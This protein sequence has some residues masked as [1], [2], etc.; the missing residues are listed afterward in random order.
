MANV[1]ALLIYLFSNSALANPIKPPPL[2]IS[3][4]T[5]GSSSGVSWRRVITPLWE[6]N[7]EGSFEFFWQIRIKLPGDLS[8]KGIQ[9]ERGLITVRESETAGSEVLF[10]MNAIQDTLTIKGSDGR[11]RTFLVQLKL[12]KFRLIYQGCD[13][14]GLEIVSPE[15][16]LKKNKVPSYM[17]YRCDPTNVGFTLSIS[18]PFEHRWTFS[19]LFEQKGKGKRWRMFDLNPQVSQTE[20]NEIGKFNLQMGKK[21]MPFQIIIDRIEVARKIS[22]FRFSMGV[23]QMGLTANGVPYQQAKPG[24]HMAFEVRPFNA[25]ISFGGMGFASLP[26]IQTAEYF[27]QI[28]AVGYSGYTFNFKGNWSVEPRIYLAMAEGVSQKSQQFFV[29]SSPAIGGTATYRFG[30]RWS[31]SVELYFMDQGTQAIQ[32]VKWNIANETKARN[33]WGV[34]FSYDN[35]EANRLGSNPVGANQIFIGPF[36]DY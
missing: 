10:K 18:T 22:A 23:M 36:L 33:G 20:R 1:F 24:A 7:A 29:L 3:E 35:M 34:T 14:N 13:D 25:L 12:D 9:A 21:S 17:A 8:T 31:T 15:I 26:S 2:S 27:T 16:N 4:T 11:D 5:G 19:T 6:V 30:E 32:S 28:N